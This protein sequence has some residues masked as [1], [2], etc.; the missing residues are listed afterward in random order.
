MKYILASASPRRTELL[1]QAGFEF[2]VIPS[3]VKETITETI[4]SEIVMDLAVQKAQD[5]FHHHGTADCVVIGADTIV[6]YRD[7]IMGKPADKTEAYDMLSMLADRTHQ[8]YT[9]VALVISQKGQVRTRTFYEATDVTLCP[10]SR[11]DLRAYVETADPLDKAGAYGIQ[12]SF[13]VHV[14][15]ISGD[16]NNVVGLPVCRLYQELLKEKIYPQDR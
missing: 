4:P 8:V 13:A 7:E 5:V 6:V 14:R 9:G 11:E 16:Y 15:R 3:A 12:G 1:A 2:E 10:I